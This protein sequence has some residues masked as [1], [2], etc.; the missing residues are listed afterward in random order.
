MLYCAQEIK[1]WNIA[2]KLKDGRWVVARP[3]WVSWHRWKHAWW[4]L[5]GRCDAIWW[6]EDDNPHQ[7][8]KTSAS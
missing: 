5:T 1:D 7:S 4:V 6:P 2:T 8:S 3:V